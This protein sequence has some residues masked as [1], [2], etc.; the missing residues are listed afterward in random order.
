M[1]NK[2][3]L[4]QKTGA[5]GMAV[6]KVV[7]LL[8]KIRGINS[9]FELLADEERQISR[10][11]ISSSSQPIYFMHNTRMQVSKLEKKFYKELNPF[12]KEDLMWTMFAWRVESNLYDEQFQN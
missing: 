6:L 1:Q 11:Q 12:K 7:E 5:R 10:Q 9:V 8:M 3:V 4:N 2:F